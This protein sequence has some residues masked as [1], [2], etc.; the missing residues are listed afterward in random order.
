MELLDTFYKEGVIDCYTFVFSERSPQTGYYAMLAT[1]EDGVK[2]SQWT[3]GFYDPD[4]TNEHLGKR[5]LFQSL[6]K[7]LVEHVIGRMEECL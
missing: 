3:D 2:F 6:G 7:V 4:G 1:D 5:V